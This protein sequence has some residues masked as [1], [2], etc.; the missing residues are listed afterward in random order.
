MQNMHKVPGDERKIGFQ[1][2]MSMPDRRTF[3]GNTCSVSWWQTIERRNSPTLPI[4][5]TKKDSELYTAHAV[6]QHYQ[7]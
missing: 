3:P 2:E 4:L 5:R 6:K 7:I 1:A